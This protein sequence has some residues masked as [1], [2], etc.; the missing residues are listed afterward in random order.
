MLWACGFTRL[1]RCQ[2]IRERCT[3]ADRI[4]ALGDQDLEKPCGVRAHGRVARLGGVEGG[5]KEFF[6][7]NG[8]E[9]M[10]VRK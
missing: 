6:E 9:V 7:C 1:G 10:R 2:N 3:N 4:D 8:V 5:S